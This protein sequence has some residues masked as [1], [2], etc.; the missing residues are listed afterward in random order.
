M[1]QSTELRRSASRFLDPHVLARI[2]SL[3]LL[4]RTVVSGFLN[5]LHRSPYF[6]L[7]LDFAEHR[8]YMPGDDIRRVDWRLY[9]RT[10]RY[11]VKEFE[12]DTNA[13][14]V[15]LLDVSRSMGYSGTGVP[16]LDYARYLAACLA[17]FVRQ[18]RDRIGLVT[19]D[20]G[21]VEYVPPSAKRLETVLHTLEHIRPET[22]R[23]GRLAEPLLQ[24]TERLPSRGMIVLVSDFYEEPDA[25]LDAVRPLVSRGHDVMA[26]HL[27]DPTEIEFPFD[28]PTYFEEL[29]GGR[30]LPVSPDKMRDRYR[31]MVREHVDT[32]GRRFAE[33]RVDYAMFDTAKPLDFGLFSFLS[34]RNRKSRVR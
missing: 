19:F 11:Y 8:G 10:D 29:E 17:Y 33:H 25:V 1:P 3:E 14:F 27:L 28:E 23:E 7:S 21:I 9:A 15:L 32:L 2:S 6:G 5:G 20:E 31:E 18:Q 24:I 16:K 12:A 26:F 30:R 4:A 13:N 34:A 22:G